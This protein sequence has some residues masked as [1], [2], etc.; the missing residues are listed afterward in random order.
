MPGSGEW[1]YSRF[2]YSRRFSSDFRFILFLHVFF[3]WFLNIFLFPFFSFLLGRGVLRCL[4][5]ALHFEVVFVSFGILI[6][7]CAS[8]EAMHGIFALFCI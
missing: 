4:C 2:K 5:F 1:A 3:W 6:V 8:P 7:R